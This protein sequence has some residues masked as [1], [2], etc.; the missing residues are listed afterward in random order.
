MNDHFIGHFL[1]EVLYMNDHFIGHFLEE[2]LYMNDHFIGHFK[3]LWTLESKLSC[4]TRTV[5]N[6][7]TDWI[8]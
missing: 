8:I 3:G 2:V 6:A 5:S 7:R 4:K 1:E